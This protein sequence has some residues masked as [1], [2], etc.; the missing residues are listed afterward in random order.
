MPKSI[1]RTYSKYSHEAVCLMGKLIK[2][3]RKNRKYTTQELAE[4][5]GISRGLLRRIEN[6]DPKCEIG[7]VFEVA[8]L[9]DVRLF[10]TDDIGLQNHTERVNDKLELLPKTVRKSKDR[11]D[12]DF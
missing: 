8:S 7:V 6:G 11:V 1:L 3:G 5:A 4:R 10:N 2:L 12:D 9:V